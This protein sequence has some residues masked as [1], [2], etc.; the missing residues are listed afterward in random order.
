VQYN[1]TTATTLEEAKKIVAT[2]FEY[3]RE[4]KGIQIF[5]KPK[6]YIPKTFTT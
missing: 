3:M 5:R 1:F 2:G 4:M 6:R